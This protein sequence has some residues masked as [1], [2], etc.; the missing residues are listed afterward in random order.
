M[1]ISVFIFLNSRLVISDWGAT[2]SSVKAA[3][4]GLDIEMPGPPG[5]FGAHLTQVNTIA[6]H[7][8]IT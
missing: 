8:T 5:W 4:A 1:L 6:H 7:L 3:N 2:H